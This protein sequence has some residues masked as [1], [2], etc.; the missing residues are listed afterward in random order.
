MKK[1]KRFAIYDIKPFSGVTIEYNPY[2]M[3]AVNI[4]TAS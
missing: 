1:M 2:S 3:E 4:W